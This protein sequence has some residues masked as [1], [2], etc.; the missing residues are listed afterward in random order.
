MS[1]KESNLSK[2]VT[3]LR[4]KYEFCST[5]LRCYNKNL[6]KVVTTMAADLIHEQKGL[7][8]NAEDYLIIMYAK[9]R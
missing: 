9:E 2:I 5:L 7:R 6:D 1:N 8:R 4:I 3:L